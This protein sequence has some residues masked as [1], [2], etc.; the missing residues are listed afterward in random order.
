M[1]FLKENWI[2]IVAP[3][4]IVLVILIILARMADSGPGDDFTYTL[5]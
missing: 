4:L 2:W 5:S 1:K 3:V